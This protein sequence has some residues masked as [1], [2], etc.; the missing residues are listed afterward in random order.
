MQS[1]E[2]PRK[3]NYSITTTSTLNHH[4]Q[5]FGAMEVLSFNLNTTTKLP[6]VGNEYTCFQ[7]DV[8]SVQ[9]A[10]C[11]KSKIMTY[12]IDYVVFINT[13]QQ[14]CVV[15]KGMLQSSCLKTRMNTIDIDQ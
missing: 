6:P 1:C 15:I 2:T 14:Q 5:R 3:R 11:V 4:S 8:T 12:V 13:F 10:K 7:I 9:A